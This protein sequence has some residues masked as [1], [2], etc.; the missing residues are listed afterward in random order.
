[1]CMRATA[2]S[3]R[4]VAPRTRRADDTAPV[5]YGG[6]SESATAFRLAALGHSPFG[7][8]QVKLEWEV[9]PLGD[10]VH[11]QRDEPECGLAGYDHRGRQPQ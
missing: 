8:T 5:A 7:R 1:M 4:S 3:G 2:G 6:Q 10:V 9:K 11:G